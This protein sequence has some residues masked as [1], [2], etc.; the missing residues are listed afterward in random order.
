[1]IK[2]SNYDDENTTVN[3]SERHSSRR[4]RIFGR[5]SSRVSG[6]DAA[7]SLPTSASNL[8]KSAQ[9]LQN[10]TE[11][12]HHPTSSHSG[13]DDVISLLNAQ[14]STISR[15]ITQTTDPVKI[16]ELSDAAKLVRRYRKSEVSARRL[17]LRHRQDLFKSPRRKRK[18]DVDE[19]ADQFD[20]LTLFAALQK[21]VRQHPNL[22]RLT[23]KQMGIDNLGEVMYILEQI[24]NDPEKKMQLAEF[25][26]DGLTEIVKGVITK[27]GPG[28]P[29]S[30]SPQQIVRIR[31]QPRLL[32]NSQCSSTL[33]DA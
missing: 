12:L 18:F 19:I 15:Q 8:Q 2:Q 5:T 32:G 4:R 13:D 28:K 6:S 20:P 23:A 24:V 30:I 21:Q 33:E 7:E 22:A 11:N 17:R 3:Q 14:L 25:V 16:Q 1:M 29:T 10:P 27:F 9:S 26:S 31:N